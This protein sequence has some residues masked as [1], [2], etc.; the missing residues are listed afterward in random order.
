[1]SLQTQQREDVE[2]GILSHIVGLIGRRRFKVPHIDSHGYASAIRAESEDDANLISSECD[3]GMHAP[4]FD[5]DFGA[6]LIPS[7][8]QGNNHL[9]IEKKIT[10]TQY[11]NILTALAEAGII[12]DGWVRSAR[13]DKRAYLRL[14][15]IRKGMY[16]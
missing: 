5:L 14:P 10:W 3:D 9:Y 7:S 12:Q 4:I 1:M 6:Y 2:R 11:E 16:P 13:R 15:H 8:T